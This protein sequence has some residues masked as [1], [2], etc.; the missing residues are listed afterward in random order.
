[1]TENFF[2][3]LILKFIILAFFFFNKMV[4]KNRICYYYHPEVGN[5][6]YGKIIK[7]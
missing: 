7:F 4:N 3:Y 5:F 1:M 6:H 2:R